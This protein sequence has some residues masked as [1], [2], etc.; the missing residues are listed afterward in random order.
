MVLPLISLEFGFGFYRVLF[1]ITSLQV[2]QRA[3][4]SS[5]TSTKDDPKLGPDSVKSSKPAPTSAPGTS[6]LSSPQKTGGLSASSPATRPQHRPVNPQGFS[7]RFPPGHPRFR[8]PR[9][10]F[11]MD[12]AN[13]SVHTQDGPSDGPRGRGVPR[14]LNPRGATGPVPPRGF[15]QSPN[16]RPP[17]PLMMLPHT[18]DQFEARG[19]RLM[20]NMRGEFRPERPRFQGNS[21]NNNIR[22][23]REPHF[24]G[25]NPDF[26]G[27]RHPGPRFPAP[28]DIEKMEPV[29]EGS[30]NEKFD[31]P[32]RQFQRRSFSDQ[33]QLPERDSNQHVSPS[34]HHTFD[35]GPSPGRHFTPQR[36]KSPEQS[37]V[38]ERPMWEDG[39]RSMEDSMYKEPPADGG[40]RHSRPIWDED[41]RR[42]FDREQLSRGMGNAQPQKSEIRSRNSQEFGGNPPPYFQGDRDRSRDPQR[43][44]VTFISLPELTSIRASGWP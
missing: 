41:K 23:P 29:H 18:P 11:D 2:P 13:T 31:K 26:R 40:R 20:G 27:Q 1:A 24:R 10:S 16:S 32:E 36:Q 34:R 17:E 38:N 19:P 25:R 3:A 21:P 30:Q 8:P 22:G 7:P 15:M 6:T 5:S 28:Q 42:D 9:N 14:M 39:S 43:Q 4:V 44:V 33:K 35:Q 12:A 37:F